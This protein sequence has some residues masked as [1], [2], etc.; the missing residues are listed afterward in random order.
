MAAICTT[1]PR[2]SC[3][4]IATHRTPTHRTKRAPCTL[5]LSLSAVQDVYVPR[6]HSQ[7]CTRKVLVMEWVE[8]ERLRTAYSAA[9]EGG[10]M[11][12]GVSRGASAARGRCM[13]A[14]LRHAGAV[15][16]G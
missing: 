10:G 13:L 7:L 1:C 15:T 3:S 2:Q 4:I 14:G 11:A 8:G 9:R 5:P 6:M 16:R 12:T